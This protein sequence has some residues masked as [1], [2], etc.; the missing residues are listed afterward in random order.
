MRIGISCRLLVLWG[1]ALFVLASCSHDGNNPTVSRPPVPGVE[2]DYHLVMDH[3]HRV[4]DELFS[5]TYQLAIQTTRGD[6]LIDSM[7]AAF[8]IYDIAFSPNGD[9]VCFSGSLMTNRTWISHWP[10]LDTIAIREG[11]YGNVSFS[12]DGRYLLV[13]TRL[14]SV[15]D[16]TLIYDESPLHF[17]SFFI[18][19]RDK[20]CFNIWDTD[21][22]YFVDYGITPPLRYSKP[23]KGVLGEVLAVS[24]FVASVSGDSLIMAAQHGEHGIEQ[25]SILIVDSDSFE[26]I[27]QVMT[28]GPYF[29]YTTPV[30]HPNGRFVYWYFRGCPMDICYSS[31]TVYVYDIAARSLSVL[32]DKSDVGDFFPEELAVTPGGEYLYIRDFMDRMFKVN[33]SNGQIAEIS[34]DGGGM[35]TM[36]FY[37]LEIK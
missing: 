29:Q 34:D 32:V 1:I 21:S 24:A 8:I 31:G 18:P 3:Y 16:M 17:N 19:G 23:V 12:E 2:A 6:T 7:P 37:P 30:I 27:D 11:I 9:L 20:F 14:F 5:Y 13:G 33:T 25:R 22:I 35:G 26:I 28:G 10:K 4:S 15:P 36:A